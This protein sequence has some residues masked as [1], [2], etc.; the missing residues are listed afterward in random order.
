MDPLGDLLI[1][2]LIQPGW[3]ISIE[4]YLNGRFR[5]ID[6]LDRQ[7]TIVWSWPK[8][9]PKLMVWKCFSHFCQC[10]FRQC[11]DWFWGIP[12]LMWISHCRNDMLYFRGTDKYYYRHSCGFHR[13]PIIIIVI[14]A[15]SSGCD[16]ESPLGM[17]G[18][19]LIADWTNL[20]LPFDLL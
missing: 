8:P 16:L 15:Q 12:H 14:S 10:K 11:P 6:I 4:R 19:V 17:I 3:V 18:Y 2:R 5:C 7:L 9:L 13:L 1:T 20:V